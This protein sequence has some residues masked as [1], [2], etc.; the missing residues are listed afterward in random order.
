VD[1]VVEQ[2]HLFLQLP[3]HAVLLV[4]EEAVLL[5]YLVDYTVM[6]VSLVLVLVLD[7]LELFLEELVP[8][9]DLVLE[10]GVPVLF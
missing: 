3:G 5:L 8:V 7:G 9:A 6:L 10:V 1:P 4:L 2:G